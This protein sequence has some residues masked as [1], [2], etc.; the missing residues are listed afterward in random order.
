M[1]VAALEGV[2]APRLV[3]GE[4]VVAASE[5]ELGFHAGHGGVDVR[6]EA[7][8]GD[9]GA[10]APEC[11]AVVVGVGVRRGGI[12]WEDWKKGGSI[13]GWC[14]GDCWLRWNGGRLVNW[15]GGRWWR[16]NIW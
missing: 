8:L 6:D 4:G 3:E 9:G 14:G 1:P 13:V 12:W 16:W 11:E 10:G 2:E 5:G 7:A 15:W